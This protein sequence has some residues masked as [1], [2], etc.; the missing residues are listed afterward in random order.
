MES[1]IF[2]LKA[3]VLSESDKRNMT[4]GQVAT[5]IGVSPSYFS[6]ILNGKKPLKVELCNA[7]ADFLNVQ[8]TYLYNLVGWINLN[9]EDAFIEQLREYFQQNPDFAE[10]VKMVLEIE[11][12][13]ERRRLIRVIRAGMSN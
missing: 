9:S 12:E 13:E 1:Q 11:N 3:F 6:E 10:F 8:R 4:L 7:I 5:E 2:A